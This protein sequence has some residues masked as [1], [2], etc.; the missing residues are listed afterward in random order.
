MVVS[1][2]PAK[3]I[4]LKTSSPGR[5][6]ALPRLGAEEREGKKGGAELRYIQSL[7]CGMYP[8]KEWSS[9][10]YDVHGLSKFME[11]LDIG[12]VTNSSRNETNQICHPSF[13]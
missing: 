10:F 4:T 2:L 7:T 6:I 8:C 3:T 1:T 13:L 11:S 9:K 5:N 12:I